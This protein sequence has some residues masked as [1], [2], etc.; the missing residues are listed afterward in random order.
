MP[1]PVSREERQRQTRA[2]LIDAARIVF[3][4]EGYHAARLDAV[5]AEAGY[6]KGAVYSNFA[7]KPDLFLAVID[8]NVDEALA[9]GAFS[10]LQLP[11]PGL[12][13]IEEAVSRGFALATLEFAASAVRDPVLAGEVAERMARQLEVFSSEASKQRTSSDP[14][15]A[16]ELGFFLSALDQGTALHMLTSDTDVRQEAYAEVIARLLGR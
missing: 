5:A 12:D 6:T 3:A 7:G 10:S 14:L 4:R 2:Q 8:A 15:S 1:N 16:A 13:G 9:A 11:G